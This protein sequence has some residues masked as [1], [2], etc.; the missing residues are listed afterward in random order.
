MKDWKTVEDQA[1]AL[2]A[3]LVLC[4]KNTAYAY[5]GLSARMEALSS[6]NPA[7]IIVGR[8]PEVTSHVD[9]LL[10]DG[11]GKGRKVVLIPL[12]A[13]PNGQNDMWDTLFPYSASTPEG[14]RAD[15]R[16]SHRSLWLTVAVIYPHNLH[17]EQRKVLAALQYTHSG[18]MDAVVYITIV[19]EHL[20][21]RVRQLRVRKAN[22]ADTIE[23]NLVVLPN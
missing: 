13:D 15:R 19:V 12:T 11:G 22:V 21:N 23:H 4:S 14:A 8:R 5:E 1:L 3:V 6:T 16:S 2:N 17:R 20:L 10:A 7:I 18:S 9:T